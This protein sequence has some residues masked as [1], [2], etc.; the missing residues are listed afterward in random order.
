MWLSQCGQIK[1]IKAS[2][3]YWSKI[4]SHGIFTMVFLYERN[5]SKKTFEVVI[6]LKNN[7]K[8]I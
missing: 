7:N 8:I 5:S 6:L 2:M 4:L 1:Q 3:K